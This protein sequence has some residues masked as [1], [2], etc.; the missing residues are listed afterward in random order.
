M[1]PGDQEPPQG[2]AEVPRADKASESQGHADMAS[3]ESEPLVKPLRIDARVMGEQFD[4]LAAFGARLSDGPLHQLF[5]DAAAA[6][7]AGDANVLDQR[8]RGALRTQ[9]RQD[10]ELQAADDGPLAVH[11]DHELEVRIAVDRLERLE[12]AIRQRIFEPLPRA[13]ERIVRQHF[14]DDADVVAAGAAGRYQPG[15]RQ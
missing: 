13:A 14:D 4:Q 3:P 2:F 15:G 9:S 1:P 5:A 7:T 12:I 11:R 8:A 6:A 10:A